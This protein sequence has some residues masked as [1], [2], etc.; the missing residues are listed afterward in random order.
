[1]VRLE[2]GCKG[3]AHRT[4]S[5]S[6]TSVS[7]KGVLAAP[8]PAGDPGLCRFDGMGLHVSKY[9]VPEGAGYLILSPHQVSGEAFCSWAALGLTPVTWGGCGKPLPAARGVKTTWQ[10]WLFLLVAKSAVG[11]LQNLKNKKMDTRSKSEK[12]QRTQRAREG[13]W[14][15]STEH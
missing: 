7:G 6:S 10:M 4:C 13:C 14:P 1:M 11:F 15:S 9:L 2:V 8:N 3:G 12:P 5:K